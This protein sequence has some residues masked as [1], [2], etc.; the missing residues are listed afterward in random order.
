MNATLWRYRIGVASRAVAAI[1]GGYVL[2]ALLVTVLSLSLPGA[3]AEATLAATLV[4]FALYAAAVVWVFAARSAA[5]A[6]LGL[7]VPAAMLALAVWLLRQPGA[8]G[9]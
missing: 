8:T 1:G 4:S 7:S 2:T 9:G 3:R 5:R 6:W